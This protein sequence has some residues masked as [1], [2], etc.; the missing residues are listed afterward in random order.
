M[1]M[2]DD[3]GDC[4]PGYDCV[5]LTKKNIWSA[6]V[7]EEIPE[8]GVLS[9]TACILAESRAPIEDERKDQVCTG[10]QDEGNSPGLGGA[11]N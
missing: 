5:D 6:T 1:A 7:I 11:K 4:R 9:K 10:W 2:C 8:D 3:D